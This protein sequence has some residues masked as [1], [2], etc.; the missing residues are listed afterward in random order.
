MRQLRWWQVWKILRHNSSCDDASGVGTGGQ[1]DI[2]NDP[3]EKE[4]EVLDEIY[5]WDRLLSL[6][7]RVFPGQK[8]QLRS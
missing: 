6:Q 2:E 3:D 8:A 7:K 5:P 4:G 1:E